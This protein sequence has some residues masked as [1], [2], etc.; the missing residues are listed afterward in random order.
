M[1]EKAESPHCIYCGKLDKVEH[2]VVDCMRWVNMGKIVINK[3]ICANDLVRLMIAD[4]SVWKFGTFMI[5][6]IM[7]QKEKAEIKC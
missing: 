7:E 4:K 1:I 3:L 5:R 6:G 2:T